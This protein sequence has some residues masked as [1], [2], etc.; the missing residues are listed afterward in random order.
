MI[1]LNVIGTLIML[2]RKGQ[3]LTVDLPL[4]RRELF[5]NYIDQI[6][7]PEDPFKIQRFKE[8]FDLIFPLKFVKI[9]SG[10]NFD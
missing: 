8:K 6:N 3:S 10:S 1:T 2:L 9:K 7:Y 5:C 4:F